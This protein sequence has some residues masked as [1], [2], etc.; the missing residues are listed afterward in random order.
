MNFWWQALHYILLYTTSQVRTAYRR[1]RSSKIAPYMVAAAN[2]LAGDAT[3][4]Q[5]NL[6]AELTDGVALRSE[7]S[8]CPRLIPTYRRGWPRGG[9]MYLASTIAAG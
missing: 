3:Y 6:D 7:P 1:E 4:S 9:P 2:M 5:R 8:C